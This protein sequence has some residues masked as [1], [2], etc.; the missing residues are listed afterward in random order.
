MTNAQA[1]L[2]LVKQQLNELSDFDQL[3]ITVKTGFGKIN[4][5]D[6]NKM[7]SVRYTELESNVTCTADVIRLIK[8]IDNQKL[9][10]A[11]SFTITFDKGNARNMQVQDF[12]KI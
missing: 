11:L 3:Q 8:A 7:H 2:E 9:T 10:G 1:V 4:K 5:V 6:Y 12:K